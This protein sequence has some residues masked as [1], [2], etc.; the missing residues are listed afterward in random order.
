MR[1]QLAL[2]LPLDCRLNFNKVTRSAA[3]QARLSA[4]T[5]PAD[6]CLSPFFAGTATDFVSHIKIRRGAKGKIYCE[7]EWRWKFNTKAPLPNRKFAAPFYDST[8][9]CFAFRGCECFGWTK[10]HFCLN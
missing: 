10:L 1:C 9:S 3:N 6:I 7:L 8:I 4:D 5:A 2:T